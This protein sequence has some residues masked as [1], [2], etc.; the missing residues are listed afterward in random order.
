MM[1]APTDLAPRHMPNQ[2]AGASPLSQARLVDLPGNPEELRQ[3][4]VVELDERAPFPVR[5][6]YWIHGVS[7][8]DLR[9]H[10]AHRTTQQLMVAVNGAF[11][12]VLDDGRDTRRFRLDAPTRALWVPGGLWRVFETLVDGSVM[13]V[14]ASSHFDEREYIR[15]YDQYLAHVGAGTSA[16][17]D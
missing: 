12:V 4:T 13:L 15:D 2:P 16:S 17:A 5:R 10:H 14:M 7:A 8:G 1:P 3:V 9:G 11:E 6:V